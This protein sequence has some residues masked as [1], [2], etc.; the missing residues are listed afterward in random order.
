LLA[1]PQRHAGCFLDEDAA[2]IAQGGGVV[3]RVVVE[4]AA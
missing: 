1:A 4:A 3:D 2:A